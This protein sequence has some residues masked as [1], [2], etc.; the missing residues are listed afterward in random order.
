MHKRPSSILQ[1]FG[2]RVHGLNL[3]QFELTT[4]AMA[5]SCGGI[6]CSV[7]KLTDVERNVAE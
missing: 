2:R 3:T 7:R 4:L 1:C 6:N 5:S